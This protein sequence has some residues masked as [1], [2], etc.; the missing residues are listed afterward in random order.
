MR[1]M[2]DREWLQVQVQSELK[3]ALRVKAA[4]DKETMTTAIEALVRLYVSG[5]VS[6]QGTSELETQK[7]VAA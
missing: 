4:Q 5:N 6:L 1:Q 7:K 2:Q 3:H